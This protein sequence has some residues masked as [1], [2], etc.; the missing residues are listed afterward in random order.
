MFQFFYNLAL[1]AYQ[2][3][4]Y[5]SVIAQLY[6]ALIADPQNP[7]GYVL[8]GNAYQQQQQS[9]KALEQYGQALSI[10]PDYG[11]V[12]TNM[13]LIFLG[14]NQPW[15][16]VAHFQKSL[17]IR[18]N[19]AKAFWFLG[20]TLQELQLWPEAA[21]AYHA[22]IHL[23]PHD[24]LGYRQMGLLL[25]QHHQLEAA[26][27]YLRQ[28][29]Q[30]EPNLI[31]EFMLIGKI[32]YVQG[33]WEAVMGHYQQAFADEQD[34]TRWFYQLHLEQQ[35]TLRQNYPMIHSMLLLCAY[36]MPGISFEQLTT[37]LKTWAELYADPLLP[38][39]LHFRNNRSPHRRLRVG[40]VS[41]EFDN[42]SS[43]RSICL[44]LQHHDSGQVELFAYSDVEVEDAITANIRPFFHHWRPIF[45][46]D[47]QAV[48]N[49]VRADQIDILVDLTGHTYSSRLLMFAL[50]PA[51]IQ[52]TGLGFGCSTGMKAMDYIFAD[53]IFIAHAEAPLLAEKIAPLSCQIY[54]SPPEFEIELK[55]SPFTENGY[56]TFGSGNMLYK[57][58]SQVCETW[59]RILQACPSAHLSLKTGA[60]EDPLLRES[61][62]QKFEVR[63]I[64]RERITL[65]GLSSRQHHVAFYG[66][67][68]IVLDPFPYSGGIST[69][70]SLWMGTPVITLNHMHRTSASILQTIGH[71]AFIAAN[72]EDY[73]AL[74]VQ[75]ANNPAPLAPLRFKLRDALQHSATCDGPRF[76]REVEANYHQ[77]WQEWLKQPPSL[78]KDSR[79]SN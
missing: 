3:G 76:A 49:L 64:S 57:L 65:Y 5:A 32:L 37:Q 35:N 70:E 69:Y 4:D 42:H 24:P 34:Q 53:P 78:C 43:V 8:L 67:L 56:V 25:H 31:A 33:K 55:A 7:D 21:Q 45:G 74:A 14:L 41:P 27:A 51:P 2:A 23:R 63:G 30:L 73:V 61:W 28:A 47:N 16:A 54:W 46:L 58:N 22:Y 50:K 36:G 68:D 44:L 66:Q 10:K 29:L 71:P 15:E 26:L 40:Y 52:V 59:V 72:P 79:E 11:E 75:L 48:A 19:D 38:R 17:Q 9:E 39:S 20:T 60:F 77:M 13:G 12:Y 1:A 62:F 18:I 6:Q